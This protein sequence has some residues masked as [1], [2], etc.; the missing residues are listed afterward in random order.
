MRNEVS[1]KKVMKKS[2]V[3]NFFLTFAVDLKENSTLFSWAFRKRA[4][5]WKTFQTVSILANF[6]AHFL[7]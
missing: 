7:S 2:L 6:K 5:K 4:M 3:L 1:Q